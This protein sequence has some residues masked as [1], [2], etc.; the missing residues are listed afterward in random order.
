MSSIIVD[1]PAAL[2]ASREE[3]ARK[4][5]VGLETVRTYVTRLY[6]K[7]GVGSREELLRRFLR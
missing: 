5:G 6:K 1:C 2:V 7:L 4:A 3:I